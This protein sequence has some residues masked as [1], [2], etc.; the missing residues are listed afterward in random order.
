VRPD[1][2]LRVFVGAVG[3]R[4]NRLSDPVFFMLIGICAYA[5][6]AN[7][8]Y[9]A[10]PIAE[11]GFAK[12]CPNVDS[13]RFGLHAFRLGMQFS[14]ALTFFPAVLCWGTFL[15][16]LASGHHVQSPR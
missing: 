2:D 12:L 5:F 9:T 3:W 15:Y 4:G 6:M 7:L 10:G 1:D 14:I 13:S 16:Y 11:I 8:C